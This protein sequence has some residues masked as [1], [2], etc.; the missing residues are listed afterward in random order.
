VVSAQAWQ[1]ADDGTNAAAAVDNQLCL[2]FDM[3]DRLPVFPVEY[4][5]WGLQGH[6]CSYNLNKNEGIC[7]TLREQRIPL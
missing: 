7:T 4:D 1:S 6:A 5:G 3:I 2:N